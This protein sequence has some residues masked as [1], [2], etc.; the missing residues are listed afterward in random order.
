MTARKYFL[1]LT[2]CLQLMQADLFARVSNEAHEP[3]MDS[4]IAEGVRKIGEAEAWRVNGGGMPQRDWVTGETYGSHTIIIDA[5][6]WTPEV[7]DDVYYYERNPLGVYNYGGGLPIR[8]SIEEYN[9]QFKNDLNYISYYNI[10][11]HNL[12]FPLEKDV[13]NVGENGTQCMFAQLQALKSIDNQKYYNASWKLKD[14]IDGVVSQASSFSSGRM[15]CYGIANMLGQFGTTTQARASFACEYIGYDGLDT[16]LAWVRQMGQI[17]KL[18]SNP[19]QT[20]AAP[21]LREKNSQVSMAIRNFILCNQYGVCRPD[22]SVFTN[23]YARWLYSQLAIEAGIDKIKLMNTCMSLNQLSPEMAWSVLTA[24]YENRYPNYNYAGLLIPYWSNNAL[25]TVAGLVGSTIRGQDQL[26]NNSSITHDSALYF[27]RLLYR[28]PS[29]IETISASQKIYLL[30]VITDQ[31]C[32]DIHNAT[33]ASDYTNHCERICRSLYSNVKEVDIRPFMDEL[34]SSKVIWDITYRLDD[35]F[36]GFFGNENYTDF[37]FTIS[38]YWKKAYPSVAQGNS[39]FVVVKW[40]S[41]FFNS[42]SHIQCNHTTNQIS[43]HQKSRAG[44]QYL[45]FNYPDT[46]FITD[47]YS[48]V[49]IYVDEGNFIPG[50]QGV[51][52]LT[53]PAIFLDWLS[54]KQILSEAATTARVV[55]NVIALTTGV[56]ELITTASLTMRVVAAVEVAVT[57]SDMLL[58]DQGIRA[59]VSNVVGEDFLVA[60]EHIT[61]LINICVAGKGLVSHMDEDIALYVSKY[62]EKEPA[63]KQILGESSPE[64]LSMKKLNDELDAVN[65]AV[66]ATANALAQ[67]KA[68]WDEWVSKCFPDRNWGTTTFE[69]SGI[70]Y[71]SFA[72]NNPTMQTEMRGM[73]QTLNDADSYLP[74]VIHSGS[75]TPI[76]ILAHDGD[77]FYKIV[78]K[79]GNINSP[80]PYYLSESEFQSIKANP[81][82]IEQKLGLPLGS[83][84]SEYDVFT[85][86]SL[87]D[88]NAVFQSTVAPTQQFANTTPNDVFHTSGGAT[89]SLIINN[90]N[91]NLWL[92]SPMPVETISPN[93]LPYNP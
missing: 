15:V 46:T 37:I 29:Y 68:F 89:Q 59:S 47:I 91:A 54:H 84:S 87:S 23:L 92:K 53:V 30:N 73:Y 39:D 41:A 42:N 2:F 6:N 34:K 8:D 36:L 17:P 35:P 77:K 19:Y 60:Y 52:E 56:G 93:A 50:F 75:N 69:T 9:V 43:I 61:L 10:V 16:N 22:A 32:S 72:A 45:G 82:T 13:S 12:P 76:K 67:R 71:A 57:S 81:S 88:N 86:T 20:V 58:L 79:G 66:V 24:N 21:T 3:W 11:I 74:T 83:A 44:W 40:T 63:L 70:D 55:L 14:I 62:P 4:V 48:P 7:Y 38:G 18:L 80:S 85:I 25:D 5:A 90:N 51:R 27:G 64:F 78:P 28:V 65:D 33:P 1:F 26:K 31:V 49:M